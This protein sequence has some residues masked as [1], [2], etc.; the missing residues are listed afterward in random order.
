MTLKA[1]LLLYLSKFV[2]FC[3]AFRNR[4][5]C[6]RVTELFGSVNTPNYY[7]GPSQN[8]EEMIAGV[9]NEELG[10]HVMVGQSTLGNGAAGLGVFV[11]VSDGV[12]ETSI[13]QGQPVIGYS[14]GTFIDNSESAG[15]KTVAWYFTGVNQAIFFEKELMTLRDA[16]GIISDRHELQDMSHA[17]LGHTLHLEEDR[18]NLA[19][20]ASESFTMRYFVPYEVAA[21]LSDGID[22]EE[23]KLTSIPPE[24][25]YY[26]IEASNMGMYC[27]DLA[28]YPGIDEKSYISASD[29]KNVLA[30]VWRL[31][32]EDGVLFP[33]WPVVVAK[34]D[35]TFNNQDQC[36]EV[37]LG[38]NWKYWSAYEL[39]LAQEQEQEQEQE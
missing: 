9:E 38:Y 19:I 15:D 5:F 20:R 2:L 37:G 23:G 34:R 39:K 17:V 6:R 7:T 13:K 10:L 16:L 24:D 18:K 1:L 26:G 22:A 27:N 4:A 28:Y 3:N 30:L 11:A 21:Q 33:T 36:F 14:K 35:I 8:F 29:E 32:D 31:K 25:I 12:Q